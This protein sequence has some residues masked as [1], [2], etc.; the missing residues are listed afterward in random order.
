MSAS[1]PN[2]LTRDTVRPARSAER[3]GVSTRSLGDSV[4]LRARVS[5]S[6]R[7]WTP[8]TR[9]RTF[10]FLAAFLSKRLRNQTEVQM[11]RLNGALSPAVA[12]QR[13]AT[14]TCETEVQSL[15]D[16]LRRA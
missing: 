9:C 5:N 6:L 15:P 3:T 1:A 7:D 11:S 8:A 14:A 16:G 2:P 10:T 13:E 12:G 4:P